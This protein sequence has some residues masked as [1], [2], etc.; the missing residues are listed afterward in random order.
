MRPGLIS[1][2]LLD[3]TRC[4]DIHRYTDTYQTLPYPYATPA[5]LPHGQ[6]DLHG[7]LKRK[8]V[9]FNIQTYYEGYTVYEYVKLLWTW[10][11]STTR[12]TPSTS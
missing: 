10:A 8:V 11:Y 5:P 2:A 9:S 6:R 12:N 7:Y 3:V 1:Q 4:T